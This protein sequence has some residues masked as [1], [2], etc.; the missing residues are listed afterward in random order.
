[1]LACIDDSTASH[2]SSSHSLPRRVV[3]HPRHPA[4]M[5]M[6]GLVLQLQC[7]CFVYF[8]CWPAVCFDFGYGRKW[9]ISFDR[10]F[11][12]G[13]NWTSV[14]VPLSAT[15]ETRKTGF[16]RSLVLTLSIQFIPVIA[17]TICTVNEVKLIGNNDENIKIQLILKMTRCTLQN[18]TC[19]MF[20][21]RR[22][23]NYQHSDIH[24]SHAV[25]L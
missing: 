13:H 11:G 19:S 8:Y 2:P 23:Y 9:S 5:I 14:T 12:Y 1:M 25:T 4:P 20:C 22:V 3:C 7:T 18:S 17:R 10:G 16:G 21:C 24:N 6:G 15:A